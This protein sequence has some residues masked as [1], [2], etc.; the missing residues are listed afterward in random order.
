MKIK[1]ITSG[2]TFFIALIIAF[3]G[4]VFSTKNTILK[5]YDGRFKDLFQ[6]IYDK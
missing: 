1:Q 5:R 4:V 3:C 2:T 6:E